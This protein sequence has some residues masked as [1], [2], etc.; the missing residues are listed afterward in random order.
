[1]SA[2]VERLKRELAKKGLQRQTEDSRTWLSNNVKR[3]VSANI[4]PAQLRDSDRL[5][6]KPLPGRM[7]MFLYDPKLKTEL[8]YYDRFPLVF[9]IKY[10]KDGFLGLNLHYL[11]PKLRLKLFAALLEY[12]NNDK[13]NERTR[14]R[15][16]W[17]ILSNFGKSE[18]AK[19]CVKRYLYEQLKSKFVVVPPDEWEIAVFLPME[20]F[21]TNDKLYSSKKVWDET[22]KKVL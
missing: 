13:Y 19:V 5:A 8:P 18:L 15:L 22:R 10:Y 16:T 1:M 20:R 2:I 11:P 12:V 14:L 6:I 9:V 4:R 21:K 7:Y 3:V 17:R